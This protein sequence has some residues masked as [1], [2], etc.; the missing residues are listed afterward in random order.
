MDKQKIL[1]FEAVAL[2]SLHTLCKAAICLPIAHGFMIIY[3]PIQALLCV[4]PHPS[5]EYASP[6][7]PAVTLPGDRLLDKPFLQQH[8]V[9]G[10]VN[11]R[12][13]ASHSHLCNA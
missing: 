12:L 3:A 1:S 10:K 9:A 2:P 7:S 4:L 11:T 6:A 13:Y 8:P 5:I